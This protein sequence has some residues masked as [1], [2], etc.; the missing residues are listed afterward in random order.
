ME[1]IQKKFSIKKEHEIFLKNYRKYGYTDQGGIVRDALDNFISELEKKERK[2][3]LKLQAEKLKSFYE[4]NVDHT[5]LTSLD[6]E[7]FI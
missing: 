7:D 2:S 5:F 3:K 1:K 4:K 6:S